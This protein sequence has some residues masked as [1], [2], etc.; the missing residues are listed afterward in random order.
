MEK[1]RVQIWLIPVPMQPLFCC[2]VFYSAAI[3][4]MMHVRCHRSPCSA[5]HSGMQASAAPH[6]FRRQALVLATVETLIHERHAAA[7]PP[8]LSCG[9]RLPSDPY[10]AGCD[11]CCMPR[12]CCAWHGC[13][14]HPGMVTWQDC[15]MKMAAQGAEE[16]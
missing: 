1:L 2:H 14:Q 8:S 10:T 16:C 7:A 15:N 5:P 13:N 3:C 11:S 6:Q 12:R 9:C 4:Q